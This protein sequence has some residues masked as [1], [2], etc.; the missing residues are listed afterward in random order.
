MRPVFALTACALVAGTLSACGSG[1]AEKVVAPPSPEPPLLAPM[2]KARQ[3]VDQINGAQEQ[4][5]KA[6]EKARQ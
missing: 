3:A 4:R 2:N 1:P 5:D 6:I